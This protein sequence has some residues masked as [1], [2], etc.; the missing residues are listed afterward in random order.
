EIAVLFRSSFHSFDLELELQ[1][2][3]VPFIKRGGFKFIETAHIKDS[4]AH[5]RI[6]ANPADAVSWLR[7]LTLVPGIG[8]R[9]AERAIET[10][11]NAPGPQ[12]E[13][14]RLAHGSSRAS[15]GLARLAALLAA[16]GGE[17]KRPAEQ[18]AMILAYYLPLMRDAYPDDYPRRERD[19]EHFQ[20]LT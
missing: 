2:R 20:N 15:A 12:Q 7:V 14:A 10:L 6:V 8:Q 11:V 9:S 4:L 3:D 13:L 19:L 17:G 1:R 18:L 5:L 16:L